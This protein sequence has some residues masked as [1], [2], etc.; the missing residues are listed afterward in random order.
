MQ[1][2]AEAPALNGVS[3]TKSGSD[4][5]P[6]LVSKECGGGCGTGYDMLCWKQTL[7]ILLVRVTI[8]HQRNFPVSLVRG[9]RH[10]VSDM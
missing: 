3:L 5:N 6:P 2:N 4:H 10:R 1:P 7:L 9:L 8:E